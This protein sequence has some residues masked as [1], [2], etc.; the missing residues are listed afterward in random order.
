MLF[1]ADSIELTS[2]EIEKLEELLRRKT[3]VSQG[4]AER[5]RII[6]LAGEGLT[7]E[8]IIKRTGLHRNSVSKW[9]NRYLQGGIFGDRLII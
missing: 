5:A 1:V 4:V 6:I 2:V 7:N 9:R 3:S 8:E